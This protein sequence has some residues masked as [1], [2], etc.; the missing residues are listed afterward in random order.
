LDN[1]STLPKNYRNA[2]IEN[3]LNLFAQKYTLKGLCPGDQLLHLYESLG[4]GLGREFW[5]RLNE[6]EN[7]L[8]L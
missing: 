8:K 4:K 6:I 2:G 7:R 3:D 5:M 1:Y